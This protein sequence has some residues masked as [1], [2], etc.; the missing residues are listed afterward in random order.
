MENTQTSAIDWGELADI[1]E[2][3]QC[4]LFL[5]PEATVNYADKNRQT[6]FFSEL[7]KT[8]PAIHSYHKEDG[9]F[10]FSKPEASLGV[11]LKLKSFTKATSARRCWA[12]LRK[13]LFILW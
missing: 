7:E 6:N 4:V 5:G 8:S 11:Q 9:L 12:R 10:V 2:M 3:G 1:I 13:S